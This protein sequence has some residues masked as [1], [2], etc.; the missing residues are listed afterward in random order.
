MHLKSVGIVGYGAF[1]TLIH[2]LL[3]KFA[4]SVQVKVFSSRFTSDGKTFFDLADVAACDA[5]VLSVPISAFEATLKK[6]QSLLASETVIVDVATVKGHTAKL[7]KKYLKG[8]RY[9]STHPMWGPESY[10]KKGNSVH[11]LRIVITDH[12]LAAQEYAALRAA[13][14]SI[15]FDIVEMT[16]K[17]HDT[18]LASTLFLTHF[19]GQTIT[20]AQFDRT[21][22]DTLSFGFLMDAV[23]SVRHDK[24]LFQDVFKYVPEC[25]AV[26]ERFA[27]AEYAVKC[28][29]LKLCE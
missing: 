17:K 6:I 25:K 22:I 4:P 12:T 5:V 20:K 27:K 28:D 15:G 11:G 7:L 3:R 23:E 18:H 24:A 9:I 19:L 10:K 29:L 26:L 21:D 14:K 13:L 16:A 1:G 8:R 2:E